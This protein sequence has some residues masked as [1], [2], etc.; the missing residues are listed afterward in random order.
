LEALQLFEE[1]LGVVQHH[2]AVSGTAKQHTSFD[3]AKRVSVSEAA[4]MIPCPCLPIDA[5][6]IH[7]SNASLHPVPLSIAAHLPVT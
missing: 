6:I 3:Y 1:A 7:L 2:D 5:S 4:R